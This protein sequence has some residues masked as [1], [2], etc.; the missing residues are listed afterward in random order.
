[1]LMDK[2]LLAS[3]IAKSLRAF[4]GALPVVVGMLLMTSLAINGVPAGTAA[5]WFG[6]QGFVDVLIGANLFQFTFIGP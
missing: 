6:Q 5:D 3:S 1:M 2:H 4:S